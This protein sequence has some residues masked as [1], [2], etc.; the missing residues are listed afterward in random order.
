MVRRGTQATVYRLLWV[1]SFGAAVLAR[2]EEWDGRW[3]GTAV[4]FI[5][6]RVT[7]RHRTETPWQV[8]AKSTNG[9]PEAAVVSLNEAVNS[10]RFW[11][12]P[13][14]RHSPE[15]SDGDVWFIEGRKNGAYR[16]VTRDR[17]SDPAFEQ[18]GKEILRAAGLQVPPGMEP[19]Q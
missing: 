16:I 19:Q 7:P 18:F 12:I 5:D 13:A 11:T 3:Q 1:P 2:A 17:F 15:T 8:S 4:T 10:S 9:I 14:W 6:S